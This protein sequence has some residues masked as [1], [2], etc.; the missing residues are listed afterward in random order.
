[1]SLAPGTRF[2]AYEIVSQI[3]EGGMGEVY[4]ARDTKL[5]RDV[6]LKV[7]PDL[8]AS[9]ADRLARF[10]REAQTLAS[11]NHPN[12]AHIH[13][14]EESGGVRALVMELVEGDDLSQRIARG[15]IPVDEA[16]PIAK[17]IAEAL[18]AAH[19]QGV[20]HRDLKPANIKVRSDGAVKV[21]D[22][23]LAKLADAEAATRSGRGDSAPP[24]TITSPAM[25]T[26]LGVILGTAAYMS[27]EQARGN[28]ADK[29]A[30]IWA[31]G[32]VLF[33]MLTGDRAFTGET[34]SDTLASVLKTEPN[35]RALPADLPPRLRGLLRWCLNKDLK[36]RLRDIGDARA[37]IED[38]V[39][40]ASEETGAVAVAVA[41]PVWRR[42]LPWA[43]TG[44]FA[45]GLAAM[46]LWGVPGQKPSPVALMRMSA[47]LGADVS[48]ALGALDPISLSPNGTVM[49]F[50]GQEKAGGKVQL[51]VRRLNESQ[52]T[53]LSGTD[54]AHSPF[55]SPDGQWIAFFAD[56]K[57][58]K[59]AVSGGATVTLCDAPVPR[60]GDW[61]DD[62][63]IVLLPA[64]TGSLMRCSSTIPGGTQ[65]PVGTLAEGEGTQRWPQVL[66]GG[67]AVFFTASSGD[68]SGYN[69]ANLVVQRLPDGA[70]E[71]VQKGG[72]HGR[73]LS[74]GHL[75]F[76]HDGTLFAAPFDL[77]ELRVTGP[78]VPVLEGCDV[79]RWHRQCVVRHVRQRAICVRARASHRRGPTDPL[80]GSG[81]KDHVPSDQADGMAKSWV[82]ARWRPAR[83]P[84]H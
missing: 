37:Q 73:Y 51:Y 7:L 14:L 63:N 31:F 72:F 59:I 34:I 68:V 46:L 47:E 52:A 33:E 16:L 10:N 71:V 1:M 84:E 57:L 45:A 75:A 38:L 78:L 50:V 5:N 32:V 43:F 11:L 15:P 83:L 12:I 81:W 25:M 39:V 9:D 4:R 19:E 13:G 60:G 26:G 44:V 76:I 27:P 6:A 55:F 66:L 35:W 3:G 79:T 53:V 58:R 8:F 18:E 82:L 61:G 17:Q 80:D 2:G 62:G 69:D 24:P 64:R 21:L 41:V 77:E 49:A 40:G 20:I 48:L 70:R 22:F 56:G 67:R 42:V 36:R 23:G 28:V 54:G 74:S 30:D 65:E 29:R